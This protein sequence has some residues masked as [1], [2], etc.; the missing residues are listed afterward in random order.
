MKTCKPLI[1]DGYKI[2]IIT[3]EVFEK[4]KEYPDVF[5]CSEAD[6]K[7]LDELDDYES[8]YQALDRVLRDM[9]SQNMFVTLKGWRNEVLNLF[10]IGFQYFIFIIPIFSALK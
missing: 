5:N 7:L 3:Q 8:R 9:K 10:V 6:V 1:V 2:G 4:L